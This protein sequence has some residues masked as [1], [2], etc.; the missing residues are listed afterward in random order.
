VLLNFCAASVMLLHV[1]PRS[2]TL[3]QLISEATPILIQRLGSTQ[4]VVLVN[5]H[6]LCSAMPTAA[7]SGHVCFMYVYTY[8][9]IHIN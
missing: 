3:N 7:G 1:A 4:C 5:L 2:M 9:C 8:I 6:R